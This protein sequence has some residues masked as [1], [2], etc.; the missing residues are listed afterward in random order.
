VKD[1][2]IVWKI[3]EPSGLKKTRAEEAMEKPA[4]VLIKEDDSDEDGDGDDGDSDDDDVIVPTIAATLKRSLFLLLRLK[5]KLTMKRSLLQL[6]QRSRSL[7]KQLQRYPECVLLNVTRLTM[8][9]KRLISMSLLSQLSPHLLKSLR[10]ISRRKLHH[11]AL[12]P[13]E[14]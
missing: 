13:Y 10:K 6:L 2:A 12:Y 8:L 9:S 7:R 1:N 4:K 14:R 5:R 3:T 11:R